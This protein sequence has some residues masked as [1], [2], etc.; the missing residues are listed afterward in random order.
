MDGVGYTEG[1]L[2]KAKIIGIISMVNALKRL[3]GKIQKSVL[4]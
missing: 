1:F 2:L 3:E 4:T